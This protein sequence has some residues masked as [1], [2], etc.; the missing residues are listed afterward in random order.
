MS[1]QEDQSP[2]ITAMADQK[3]EWEEDSVHNILSVHGEMRRMAALFLFVL[4]FL[5]PHLEVP[6]HRVESELWPPSYTT[7][8]ARPDLSHFCDLHHS[9]WQR[10]I[11]PPLSEARDRTCV[12]MEAS[13]IHCC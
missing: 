5:G 6:M 11:L 13:Q 10:W 7:A 9:S 8:T 12:L 2:N 3:M 4:V 1:L